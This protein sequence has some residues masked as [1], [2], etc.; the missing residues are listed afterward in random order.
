MNLTP[1]QIHV[2]L[3]RVEVDSKG[4]VD[5]YK[6]SPSILEDIKQQY[7]YDI[8]L[9]KNSLF[10]KEKRKIRHRVCADFDPIEI[11][12]TFKKYDRNRNGTLDFME[13]TE[14]MKNSG[15]GFTKEEIITA[16]LQA[17]SGCNGQVDFEEFIKHFVSVFD[18]IELHKHLDDLYEDYKISEI[19]GLD[20]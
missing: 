13:Y 12:R 7:T 20:F 3:G 18:Q 2:L 14:A 19:S 15:L 6:W 9:I 4:M 1:L 11:F 10:V 17:D 16:T 8:L 5:Y